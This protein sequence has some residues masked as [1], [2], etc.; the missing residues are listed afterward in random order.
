MK[1]IKKKKEKKRKVGSL[2]TIEQPILHFNMLEVGD[3]LNTIW[4]LVN[5]FC[6]MDNN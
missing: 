6:V 2:A 5:S 4:N 1:T 3:I